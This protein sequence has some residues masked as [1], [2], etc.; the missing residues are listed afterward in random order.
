MKTSRLRLIHLLAV[1]AGFLA[2]SLAATHAAPSLQPLLVGRYDTS[3]NAWDVA[4]SG[5]DGGRSLG[6]MGAD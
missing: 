5:A 6:G 2:A 3:G 1:L 4:V